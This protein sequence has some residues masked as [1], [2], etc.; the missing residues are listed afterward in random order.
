LAAYIE[1]VLARIPDLGESLDT[2]LGHMT[3]RETS[4]TRI[5]MVAFRPKLI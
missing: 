5:V 2:P 3:I 4:G 1:E